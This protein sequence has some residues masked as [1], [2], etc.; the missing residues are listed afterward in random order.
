VKPS[1]RG[2]TNATVAGS[3]HVLDRHAVGLVDDLASI[4]PSADRPSAQLRSHIGT[5]RSADRSSTRADRR[6]TQAPTEP[7]PE[8]R[9]GVTGRSLRSICPDSLPADVADRHICDDVQCLLRNH[10][11]GTMTAVATVP[12]T[13]RSPNARRELAGANSSRSQKITPARR[14]R[15]TPSV[16]SVRR[17]RRSGGWGFS[18]PD[19]RAR[20]PR[21]VM[22]HRAP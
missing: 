21:S 4:G 7:A 12:T 13:I 1:P 18:G 2:R 9:V 8:R 14:S 15:S 22:Q 17:V 20:A 11:I 5:S 19:C 10:I 3:G 16:P 6:G